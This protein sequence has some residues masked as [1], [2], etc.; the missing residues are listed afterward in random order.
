MSGMTLVGIRTTIEGLV[1][2]QG[3]SGS[4]NMYF[5]FMG[6]VALDTLYQGICIGARRQRMNSAYLLPLF[7]IAF[8]AVIFTLF[9]IAPKL[10]QGEPPAWVMFEPAV[11]ILC[12][13]YILWETRNVIFVQTHARG[14]NPVDLKNHH[15]LNMMVNV[16]IITSIVLG[17]ASNN[18]YWSLAAALSKYLHSSLGLTADILFNFSLPLL[19][20]L[21]A[22]THPYSAYDYHVLEAQQEHEGS[23]DPMTRHKNSIT[24]GRDYG[25]TGTLRGRG[26]NRREKGS[27]SLAM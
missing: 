17:H 6:L 9:G 18:A 2:S 20:P 1:G 14:I 10:I 8:G 23:T 5:A 22:L 15:R 4:V 25:S 12:P 27:S 16:G 21:F 26:G 19:I 3:F 24:G 13:I 11:A 7:N